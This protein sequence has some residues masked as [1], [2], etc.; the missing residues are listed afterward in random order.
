MLFVTNCWRRFRLVRSFGNGVIRK[1]PENV[2]ELK[3]MTAHDFEDL[4]Q[5]S[6]SS[7][8]HQL[9]RSMLSVLHS[10]RLWDLTYP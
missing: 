3:G 4:L 10:C 6:K 7:R 5:V 8:C 1:F 9:L 2:S